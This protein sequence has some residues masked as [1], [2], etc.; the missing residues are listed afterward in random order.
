METFIRMA[1]LAVGI[2]V[3]GYVAIL[4][5]VVVSESLRDRRRKK[6]INNCKAKYGPHWQPWMGDDGD[7]LD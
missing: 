5:W 2:W 7:P 3:A 6:W 4:A 1:L